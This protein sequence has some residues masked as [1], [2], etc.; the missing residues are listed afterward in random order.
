MSKKSQQQQLQLLKKRHEN[1][2]QVIVSMRPSFSKT[3]QQSFI[4]S[5]PLQLL[6][7]RNE[8]R[9][10]ASIKN[11][12]R[13]YFDSGEISQF[14]TQTDETLIDK[15]YRKFRDKE[16]SEYLKSRIPRQKVLRYLDPVILDEVLRRGKEGRQIAKNIQT[17][18]LDD[19]KTAIQ[20]MID[21][22]KK[23]LKLKTLNVE[24]ANVKKFSTSPFFL[25]EI[26]GIH[27][28]LPH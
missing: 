1:L 2:L 26:Y 25:S 5:H 4:S 17:V 23:K 3:I 12:I 19:Q 13:D 16:Y 8:D 21:Y 24:T 6:N 22:I 18:T 10:K 9:Y 11:T 20:E 14:P 28:P 15:I 27:I 7:G